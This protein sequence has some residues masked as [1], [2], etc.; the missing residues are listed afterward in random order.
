[1]ANRTGT[2]KAWDL[3]IRRFPTGFY[4]DLAVEELAKLSA[5]GSPD[6]AEP[7]EAKTSFDL[8][9]NI[10]T[11]RAWEVFLERYKSGPYHD[12]AQQRLTALT[13]A[14]QAGDSAAGG[15]ADIEKGNGARGLRLSR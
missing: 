5:S 10:N 4:H 7:N 11:R 3:F 1:Q 13:S 6:E 2:R 8:V 14:D 15:T 9:A 12:L